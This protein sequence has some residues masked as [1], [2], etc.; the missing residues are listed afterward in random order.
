MVFGFGCFQVIEAWAWRFR[1]LGVLLIG[2]RVVCVSCWGLWGSHG[3]ALV[4]LWCFKTTPCKTLEADMY[5]EVLT[6][7]S[8]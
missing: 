4:L 7:Q 1:S 3:L 6:D 2:F 5:L 8:T